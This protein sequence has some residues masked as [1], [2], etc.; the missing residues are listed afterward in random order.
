MVFQGEE[1]K[2][3]GHVV[4]DA[5]RRR[6]LRKMEAKIKRRVQRKWEREFGSDCVLCGSDCEECE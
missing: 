4:L 2:D 5:R 1:E 6:E 3:D